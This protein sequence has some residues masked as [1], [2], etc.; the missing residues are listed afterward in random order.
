MYSQLQLVCKYLQYLFTANNGKGHGVHSPFVFDFIREVLNDSGEY[1]C[2]E[3][4]EKQRS[5]WM[6]HTGTIAVTDL[7]AGSRK[8]GNPTRNISEIAKNALKPPKY[9][10]LL[11]RIANYYKCKQILELGTSLGITSAYLGA[12]SHVGKMITLEGVPAIASLAKQTFKEVATDHI[13][14]IEGNFD[15]TLADALDQMQQID[16]AYIDGNHRL[17][18]TLR[19]FNQIMPYTHVDSLLIFDD[20][21]WSREMESAW[22]TIK[23]DSRVTLSIDLFSIGMV[24]FKPDFKVKQHFKIRF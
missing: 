17:E 21:Y 11:F 20:I 9:G 3:T 5:V 13:K 23:N 12:S 2:Y 15:N 8:R 14:L 1:Y 24:F 18:P 22:I 10:K 19:Y 7:G 6:T 16:L 4:I